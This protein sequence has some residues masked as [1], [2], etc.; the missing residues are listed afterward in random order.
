MV[1]TNCLLY[2]YYG[3]VILTLLKESEVRTPA[4]AEI[5][6]KFKARQ[7]YEKALTS[8]IGQS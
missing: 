6:A 1:V 8:L 3:L 2:E 5:D 4:N 7:T